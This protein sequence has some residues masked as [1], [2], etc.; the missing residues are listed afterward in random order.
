MTNREQIETDDI[1]AKMRELWGN[2][3][4]WHRA[5]DFAHKRE[6]INDALPD[7]YTWRSASPGLI[8]KTMVTL[9]WTAD[10]F[11]RANY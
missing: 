6:T 11:V 1:L 5:R 7:P 8:A 9:G 2:H 4:V 10:S 3:N